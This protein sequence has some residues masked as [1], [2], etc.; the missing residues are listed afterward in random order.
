[1]ITVA[2]IAD[3]RQAGEQIRRSLQ[4]RGSWRVEPSL[5]GGRPCWAEI[6]SIKP[7]LVVIDDLHV[8]LMLQYRIREARRAAPMAKIVV[9]AIGLD[10]G[11]MADLAGAGADAGVSRQL[12]A[13]T[14]AAMIRGILAGSVFHTPSPGAADRPAGR[15]AHLTP[16]EIEALRLV[17]SGLPNHHVARRMRL[18]ERTVAFHLSNVYRKLGVAN[19][20]EASHYAHMHGLL[21]AGTDAPTKAPNGPP[22]AAAA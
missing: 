15:T 18:S 12:D 5:D 6:A 14:C 19:R 17:A 7:D 13:D 21:G 9:L 16:R 11:R 1:M 3:T 10:A 8:P 4:A 2:V 20:T 22:E